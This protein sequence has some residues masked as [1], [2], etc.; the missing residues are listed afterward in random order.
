M[1][2]ELKNEMEKLGIES[3]RQ[4]QEENEMT[5]EEANEYEDLP[6][7][8]KNAIAIFNMARMIRNYSS[9]AN[10]RLLRCNLFVE[11]CKLMEG[12]N[13]ATGLFVLLAVYSDL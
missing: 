9:D 5:T 10:E 2:E 11:R 13:I 3:V 4:A 1:S 6:D 12:N 7:E 8:M